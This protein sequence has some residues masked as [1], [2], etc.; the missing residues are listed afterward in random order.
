[1]LARGHAAPD[2]VLAGKQRAQTEMRGEYV[3]GGLQAAVNACGVRHQSRPRPFK[4]GGDGIDVIDAAFYAFHMSM[5][6]RLAYSS[7]PKAVA[8]SALISAA[9][10]GKVQFPH[11]VLPKRE[12]FGYI[13]VSVG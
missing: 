6:T 8:Y 9:V 13:E 12:G 4:H 1:M 3:R 10:L 11:R 2:A 5:T 7:M